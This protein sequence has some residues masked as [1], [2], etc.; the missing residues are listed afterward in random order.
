LNLITPKI[1]QAS[2][3]DWA[4]AFVL[5]SLRMASHEGVRS[6]ERDRGPYNFSVDL[7]GSHGEF[8]LL[9]QAQAEGLHEAATHLRDGLYIPPSRMSSD[10]KTR[11]DFCDE[12][13]RLDVKTHDLSP[14]KTYFAVNARKHRALEGHCDGYYCVLSVPFGLESLHCYVSYDEVSTWPKFSLG[15]YGDP[16]YNLDLGTFLTLQ[17]SGKSISTESYSKS[18][19]L[20]KLYSES[21]YQRLSDLMP[22][23][24]PQ[25]Q[26]LYQDNL[27]RRSNT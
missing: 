27:Q 23:C 22:V 10:F 6:S 4:E 20:S 18:E 8:S 5:A 14:R 25:L 24:A 17:G 11:V 15:R 21:L 2:S 7:M 13:T 26:S 12:T 9:R 16:S 19:V 1:V 3:D